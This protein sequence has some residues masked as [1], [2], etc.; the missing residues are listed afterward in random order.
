[1]TLTVTVT[2]NLQVPSHE[3][4]H[5]HW[6]A[7]PGTF[8]FKH[9]MASVQ[10]KLKSESDNFKFEWNYASKLTL[11]TIMAHSCIS[12]ESDSKPVSAAAP[13]AAEARLQCSNV[14]C[15]LLQIKQNIMI[16][17][18]C[19]PALTGFA[20]QYS[21]QCPNGIVKLSMLTRRWHHDLDYQTVSLSQKLGLQHWKLFFG[22]NHSKQQELHR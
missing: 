14:D 7:G 1:M 11:K 20:V 16:L 8:K 10:L 3:S 13:S 12:G 21:R 22:W 9:M 18:L 15:I 4:H 17:I 6:Q 2:G 19:I 5:D